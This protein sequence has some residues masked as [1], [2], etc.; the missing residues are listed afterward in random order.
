[1]KTYSARDGID[2]YVVVPPQYRPQI[3]TGVSFLNG[4]N[5]RAQL[6]VTERKNENRIE[7]AGGRMDIYKLGD[8]RKDLSLKIT[9]S[10]VETER[11]I[12]EIINRN[13]PVYLYPR[14]GGNLQLNV[15]LV[16]GIGI[17]PIDAATA[18][19]TLTTSTGTT[20]YM[21][22]ADSG[23]GIYLEAIDTAAP[24]LDGV[25]TGNGT[26]AQIPTGRGMPF[27][28]EHENLI[29]DS[30]MGSITY[31]APYTA[32]S[33]WGAYTSA[34]DVWGTDHGTRDSIHCADAATYWTTSATTTFRSYNISLVSTSPV[35]ISFCYR[36]NGSM[37]VILRDSGASALWSKAVSSG[38]GRIQE[39]WLSNVTGA[40]AYLEF[41]L[42]SGSY[43]EVDCVQVIHSTSVDV[44][45]YYP[46]LGTTSGATEAEVTGNTLIIDCDMGA[47]SVAYTATT[48]DRDGALLASG[49]LQP[50]FGSGYESEGGT[51]VEFR[52]RSGATKAR[53]HYT[54]G[55]LKFQLFTGG[56]ARA[57]TTITGHV[58][59]DTYAWGLWTG[60]ADGTPATRLYAVR[61]RDDTAYTC[62]YAFAAMFPYRIILGNDVNGTQQ[63]DAILAA[64]TVE[65]MS[66]DS[67][68]T[69]VDR[70]ADCSVLNVIRDTVGR[71]Y[72]LDR[73]ISPKKYKSDANAGTLIATEVR[74]I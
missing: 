8:V 35:N 3:Y 25:W 68:A 14:A 13:I 36:V 50:M 53:L 23:H 11:V 71:W 29:L 4:N 9:G 24:L 60:Y 57:S 65:S 73:A 19:F 48:A 17:D 37:S 21:P 31:V 70:L 49:Y 63:A 39:S 72:T 51:F 56:T 38:A 67:C 55:A 69:A 66:W 52:A 59:G 44:T 62:N 22:R 40:G 33:E 46:F 2:C 27:F 6:T 58:L 5:L 43:M 7:L 26:S 10:D 41:T 34:S 12:E 16:R 42:A 32:G 15:P 54:G 1:M 64:V 28:M 61:L 45:E 47:D 74:A 20:V 30:L 18:T